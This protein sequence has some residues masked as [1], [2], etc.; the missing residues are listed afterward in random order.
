MERRQLSRTEFIEQY[1]GSGF[2]TNRVQLQYTYRAA[3]GG[4][5]AVARVE[6][7]PED[8]KRV[9]SQAGL[10]RFSDYKPQDVVG[11]IEPRFGGLDD[12]SKKLLPVDVLKPQYR[13]GEVK[14]PNGSS[15]FYFAADE[16]HFI[17]VDI[18]L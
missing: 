4:S 5:V 18:R 7:N 1:F 3:I 8:L 9:L 15:E 2:D 16:R 13:H 12:E 10:S 14:R 17:M 11:L 6:G